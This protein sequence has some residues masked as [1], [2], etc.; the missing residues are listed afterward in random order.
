M[1]GWTGID[2]FANAKTKTTEAKEKKLVST[3]NLCQPSPRSTLINALLNP[4]WSDAT[5]ARVASV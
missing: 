2:D 1:R 3:P 4:D 5:Y